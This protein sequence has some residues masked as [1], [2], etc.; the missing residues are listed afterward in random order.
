MNV[1]PGES[2]AIFAAEGSCVKSILNPKPRE[3]FIPGFQFRVLILVLGDPPCLSLV[4]SML[5]KS[6]ARTH[7]ASGSGVCAS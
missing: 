5:L 3:K 2:F 1:R 4:Y 7:F 6:P